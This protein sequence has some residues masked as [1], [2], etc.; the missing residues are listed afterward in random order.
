M[1]CH[2][3]Q[4]LLS[5]YLDGELPADR[6]HSLEEH[7]SS[8]CNCAKA[9]ADLRAVVSELHRL[10]ALSA[11]QGLSASVMSR[12]RHGAEDAGRRRRK[13]APVWIPLLAAAACLLVVFTGVLVVRL[14]RRPSPQ[15]ASTLHEGETRLERQRDSVA[16]KFE[17]ARPMRAIVSAAPE[18]SPPV[19]AKVAAAQPAPMPTK[20]A[21][22]FKA[23]VKERAK[24]A[25]E[26]AAPEQTLALGAKML[27]DVAREQAPARRATRRRTEADRRSEPRRPA[28]EAAIPSIGVKAKKGKPRGSAVAQEVEL[29]ALAEVADELAQEPDTAHRTITVVTND[30]DRAAVDIGKRVR[31]MRPASQRGP[32][33]A[34]SGPITVVM[35]QPEYVALL[36]DLTKAGYTLERL[37]A[38][39]RQ[40]RAEAADNRVRQA[41][42]ALGRPETLRV[43]IRFRRTV[44]EPDDAKEAQER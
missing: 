22:L 20:P 10:P 9:L 33:K 3:A 29:K 43:T 24:L 21:A 5:D 18:E 17:T 4:S 12:V 44:A 2:Q 19:T 16:A 38:P 6:A 35:T 8:C 23:E 14:G 36:T 39:R 41:E 40:A 28:P 37:L 13:I 34:V 30:P 15:I 25:A 32:S 7:T 26:R 42:E 27:K 31:T 1:H 11:P